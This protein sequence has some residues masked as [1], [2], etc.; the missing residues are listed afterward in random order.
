MV[1]IPR[2]LGDMTAYLARPGGDGPWPGV[3]VIHDALG[4][5]TDLRRQ[6]DW[7]ARAGFLALA[8]DLYYWGSRM[9][10]LFTTLRAAVAREG[11][12]FDDF[13][14]ARSWLAGQDDCTGR[15]G[16]IGVCMG[17][18]VA[19]LLASDEGYDASSVN[20]GMVPGDAMTLLAD[21]CPI[22]ASYGARDRS[23]SK[24]PAAL[25]QI[26]T[27]HGIE[28][29]VKVY[30]GAGHGFLN[31]H[32]PGETPVWAL[33]AGKFVHTRYHEPSAADARARV[34]AFFSTHLR[35]A[36]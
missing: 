29:D 8:P 21:A 36:A 4:M 20:Y 31:D 25:E 15:I 1:T 23:L 3:L 12:V 32:A 6:A 27:D 19:L 11:R 14:A 28:H 17:G 33:L 16:V 26:L 22:V 34:V 13:H 18:G 24:A 9:R 5:T 35:P 7:L 2:V 10:C 30:P